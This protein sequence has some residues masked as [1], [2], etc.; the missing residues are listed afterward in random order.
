MTWYNWA[1]VQQKLT[2]VAPI[3]DSDEANK[4]KL[5]KVMHDLDVQFVDHIW[6]GPIGTQELHVLFFSHHF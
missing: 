2:P 4:E 3:G 1:G 6:N 5:C